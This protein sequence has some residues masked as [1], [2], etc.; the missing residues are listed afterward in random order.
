MSRYTADSRDRVRDAVDM[1][2]LVGSRVEL[3]RRGHDSYFGCCPFHD[4]RTPS[5]HV[6]PEEKH[7]H[8]FGCSES[9]DP[10]D[11][12][13]RT[14]GLD[15]KGALE[16]LAQRFGV[17]LQTEEESPEAVQTRT[18]HERLY[19]LLTR[20]ATYYERYLWEST[21]AS[22]ARKYMLG[23]G[24]TEET[25]RSFRVGYSPAAWDRIVTVSQAAG[26]TGEELVAAGLA[27]QRRGSAGTLLDRF[28]GRVMFPTADARGRV[29]GFGA[30]ILSPG[31]GEAKYIN[32][33]EGEVYHKRS[34]LYGIDLAR[35]AA[36]KS[37][38]MVLAEGYTD[39]MALHQAGIRNA[40][41][42]MGTS[43]TSEQVREL[44]RLVSVLELCLDADNAG[45]EAIVR[46]AK[47]CADS[48]LELRVVMLAPGRDPGDLTGAQGVAELQ[49][50]LGESVPFVAFQV[51]R[52]L[53][54]ADLTTAE[55]KDRAIAQLATVISPLSPSML[56][57][58]LVRRSAGVLGISEARLAALLDLHGG[59]HGGPVSPVRQPA[60]GTGV[61]PVRS[62]SGQAQSRSRALLA[63]LAV[64]D[65]GGAVARRG[66]ADQTL[67]GSANI[68][69]ER[70][71]LTMCLAAPELGAAALAAIDPEELFLDDRLRRVAGLL[72]DRLS[73]GGVDIEDVTVDIAPG[74]P[75]LSAVVK[76][77]V[78]RARRGRAL[79][80]DELQHAML[81]LERDRL[82]REIRYRRDHGGTGLAELSAAHQ[83]VLDSIRRVV[84]RLEKPV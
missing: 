12:V 16:Y 31:D 28:R 60:G 9:G 20:A 56:R 68:H 23:R 36:A 62:G 29:V 13:M 65:A 37:G 66:A 59:S 48:D 25:L 55:G 30:R 70:S 39:V 49:R 44:Q 75:E 18:R 3:T 46:A 6:R 22:S 38:R 78:G 10:F 67:P 27:R 73:S 17:R 74:D 15:F 76:D 11:F 61:G 82:A 58:E 2:A 40:V 8:C 84:T 5:F 79:S 24:L 21:A 33:A 35:V 71:F 72:R 83:A 14:E 47:L 7:Y 81:L 53:A 34:V 32:T 41:G 63:P 77:L 80:A 19:G 54:G 1:V 51:E 64:P 42:I 52:T 57:D 4:E 50:R 69:A 26:Y 43:L 45:Q